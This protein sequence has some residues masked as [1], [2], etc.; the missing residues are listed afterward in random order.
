MKKWI[1][2]IIC[3]ALI[4]WM[5]IPT[6]A[7][8]AKT[9]TYIQCSVNVSTWEIL[10]SVIR[11][12]V[13]L[14]ESSL[15]L[16]R[17]DS[18]TLTEL[19][20]NSDKMNVG[21]DALKDVEAYLEAQNQNVNGIVNNSSANRVLSFPGDKI[22]STSA[23]YDRALL[24]NNALIFDLNQAFQLYLTNENIQKTS[25]ILA[26]HAAMIDFLTYAQGQIDATD[27]DYIVMQDKNGI[28]YRYR[29]RIYKGYAGAGQ[30]A[31]LHQAENGADAEYVN[32]AM[33]AFE[34][35]NNYSLTGDEAVTAESVYS[36]EPG[37]LE[38]TLVGILSGILDA[39]RGYFGL[40]TPDEI[41]FNTGSRES[42]YVGGIF[43]RNWEPTIWAIFIVME[44]FAAMILL[45]GIIN[46]VFKKALSTV[47]IRLRLEA[48]RQVQDVIVCAIV[49]A[50]L[51]MALRII[52]SMSG[53]F[54]D[55]VAAM[56]PTGADGTV[57]TTRE[58]IVGYGAGS[59]TLAGVLIQFLYFGIE[60]Y[61]SFFYAIRAL[62]VAILIMIAPIAVVMITVSDTRKQTTVMWAKELLANILIQPIQAFIMVIILILPASSHGFD[63]FIALYAMIPITSVIRGMFFGPSGSWAEQATQKARGRFT[64]AVAGGATAAGATAVV[65]T[66]SAIMGKKK[67]EKKSGTDGEQNDLTQGKSTRES[68]SSDSGGTGGFVSGI[69]QKTPPAINGLKKAAKT[70]S[71]VMFGS[72]IAGIGGTMAGSG[73]GNAAALTATGLGRAIAQSGSGSKKKN[74]PE[75]ESEQ[76]D[77]YKM[78]CAEYNDASGFYTMNYNDLNQ[79]GVKVKDKNVYYNDL[80]KLTA[81]DRA[82]ITEIASMWQ[83]GDRAWLQSQGIENVSVAKRLDKS[84]NERLSSASMTINPNK[85]RDSFGIQYGA[86]IKAK[87]PNTVPDVMAHRATNPNEAGATIPNMNDGVTVPNANNR[88]TNAV[89]NRGRATTAGETIP[90]RVANP[91]NNG[92]T[93][94]NETNTVPNAN[95]NQGSVPNV[96][97]VTNPANNR[98]KILGRV[99][100]PN[101]NRVMNPANNGVANP[102]ANN[103]VAA[104]E[105]IP[106]RVVIPN[107]AIPNVYNGVTNPANN[108]P[109]SVAGGEVNPARNGEANRVVVPNDIAL[110][111]EK[112]LKEFEENFFK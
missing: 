91:A 29:Y 46:N 52:I 88:V 12:D 105:T 58:L 112:D 45:V 25:D 101:T 71:K 99:K 51:P 17:V 10:S 59:K 8:A 34:G 108:N 106:N 28:T 70:A 57:K 47:N 96:D 92:V 11:N 64:G 79:V 60:V 41:L 24:V 7:Q 36:A 20:Q 55:M 19:A 74:E 103:R 35:F 109:G 102:N 97:G 93:A 56:I 81:A 78:G 63:N 39:I 40:W 98:E 66:A 5:I 82:N 67:D 90:N 89:H 104:G 72:A 13:G 16:R 33:L 50:L 94:T 77:M 83:S 22:D 75:P 110:Q 73:V 69:K 6:P 48:M 27:K 111:L 61:F 65:G 18:S 76:S 107:E 31:S 68:G 37:Q 23:D 15:E 42:S 2:L 3:C 62:V 85:V 49:L 43:P 26:F 84:G 44:V 80:D 95:N 38:R 14:L 87:T 9:E 32:W 21:V 54:T 1:R 30:D 53:S 100:N 86:R 4:F